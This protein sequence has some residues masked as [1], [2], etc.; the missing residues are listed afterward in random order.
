VIAR[1]DAVLRLRSARWVRDP[2]T[3]EIFRALDGLSDR[4]RAVGGVVRDTILGRYSIR[5]DLDLATELAPEEVMERAGRAGMSSY[6]TGIEHGTVTVRNKQATV[7]VTTLR[8]DVETDGRHAIVHFGKDWAEDAQRRDFTVNALYASMNGSLFD[9]LEAIEDVMAERVRFIGD[10]DA[11]IAED[12]LRVY[13]F[14]RFTAGYGGERCDPAGLAACERAAAG[15]GRLSAERV[16][17]E[18][19]KMLGLQRVAATL[20]QM[21]KSGIVSFTVPVLRGLAHYEDMTSSPV[22]MGRIAI[23]LQQFAPQDLQPMWRLSNATI[24]ES[25]EICNAA[26]LVFAGDYNMLA[27]RHA[28][29]GAVAIT[30]AAA[31]G[32]WDKAAYAEAVER[33]RRIEVP[34]FPV[35]G[36]DL[37]AAGFERGPQLGR[38]LRRIEADWV[39]SGFT[40]DRTRLLEQLHQYYS[41]PEG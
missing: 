20:A 37:V 13:R 32:D 29:L 25:R 9:P 6:P 7:E 16:G 39:R 3:Q 2:D 1:H 40:L 28:R 5:T 24:N 31:V 12:R 34:R 19:V 23:L 41:P 11:R 38:A 22:A 17:M 27:Y 26:D 33:F 15:L 21:T 14:F 4:T 30:V 36:D 8:R 18:M 35:N 10:P